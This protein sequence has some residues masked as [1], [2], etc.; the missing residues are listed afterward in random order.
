MNI[1]QQLMKHLKQTLASVRRH[2]H[3]DPEHHGRHRGAGHILDLL[4]IENG[5]SQQQIAGA[6]CI[7]PQSVSEAIATLEARGFI[8]KESSAAD[9]RITLIYLTEE[10]QRHAAILARER[11]AHAQRF[12][13][14]L[15]DDEKATLLTLLTK[16]NTT[17][18]CD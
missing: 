8:R 3:G 9:R 18:E 10:G 12:F 2:P 13:S 6:L 5:V 15:R 1:D 7:R 4:S 11:E 17:K 16:L 14:V